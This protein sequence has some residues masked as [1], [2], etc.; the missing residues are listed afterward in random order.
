MTGSRSTI[1]LVGDVVIRT[2]LAQMRGDDDGPFQAALAELERSDLVLANLEIPLSR[3]GYRIP[4][5]AN[6]RA[7]PEVIDDVKALAIDAVTLA[8]NHMMDYGPEAMLDTLAACDR[9]GIARCGA[10]VDLEAAL[11][12]L[13]FEVGATSVGLINAACTL[14]M[15][16]DAGEGKAGI[17]PIHIV[18]SYEIDPSLSL[19]QPGTMPTVHTWARTDDQ[20]LVCERVERLAAEVD[21]VIVAIHWGVPSP[22][23]N[24][25]QG[26][27]AEYQQPLGQ[28]LVTAGADIV[29]GHHAHELHPIEVFRGKP[30]MY[31]VGHFLLEN[32]WS[33]MGPHSVIAQVC[34]EDRRMTGLNLIPVWIDDRGLPG[35]ATGHQAADVVDK[36]SRLSAGYGAQ[37]DVHGESAVLALT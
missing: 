34:L 18:S 12:P 13:R 24:P 17:A 3:R 9:A 33:F 32:P 4:K 25:D 1:S 20:E 29:W 35:R 8:N 2:R 36:L 27:L 22:W 16:S 15:E 14:P 10:G 31:S 37:I 7:D 28:A 19:E 5:W 6:M 26:L 21:V 23:L 11:R 30:I